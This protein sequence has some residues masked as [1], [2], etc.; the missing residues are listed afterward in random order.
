MRTVA[1]AAGN[2]VDMGRRRAPR[3]AISVP[4]EILTLQ[5]GIPRRIPG[6][7]LNLCTEGVSAILAG[8]LRVGDSVGLELRLPGRGGVL[9]MKALVRHRSPLGCGLEFSGLPDEE[10]EIIS[11]CAIRLANTAEA[12][13]FLPDSD[14]PS[15]SL[16]RRVV[17]SIL[18]VALAGSGIEWLHWNQEWKQLES[19]T[20][21]AASQLTQSQ[22]KR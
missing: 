16:S 21:V 3:Y 7:T 6:R 19:R 4:I 5:S 11:L 18:F 22:I 1:R 15:L 10:K 13:K 8:D 17:L 20:S 9:K 14:P 2:S 12:P